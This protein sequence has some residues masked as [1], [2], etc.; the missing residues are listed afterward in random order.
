ML[1]GG[2]EVE[3]AVLLLLFGLRL[4]AAPWSQDVGKA[5]RV[6]GRLFLLMRGGGGESRVLPIVQGILYI[7]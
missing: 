1:E 3:P 5:G 4:A 2:G 6:G 7:R